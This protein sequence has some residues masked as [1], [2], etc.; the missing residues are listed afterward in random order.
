M[1]QGIMV[2]V[3]FYVLDNTNRIT[4][5]TNNEIRNQRYKIK[6]NLITRKWKL[7]FKKI[8]PETRINRPKCKC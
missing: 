3:N 5:D 1:P 7:K 6:I 8:G 2:I 4:I